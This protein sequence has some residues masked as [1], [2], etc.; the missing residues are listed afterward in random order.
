MWR[1]GWTSTQMAA[2]YIHSGAELEGKSYMEKM[3]YV[4][5]EKKALKIV[6]KT[7]PHCQAPNPYT[8]SHCDSCAMPLDLEEYK[9]EIEKR[10]EET[11]IHYS[12]T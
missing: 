11:Q 6:P 1:A 4:T 5:E 7:C 12:R 9:I 8:N 3:G 2:R 10:R